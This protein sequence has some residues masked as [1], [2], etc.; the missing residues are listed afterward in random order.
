[1]FLMK[2]GSDNMRLYMAVTADKYELPLIVSDRITEIAEYT[3][4]SNKSVLESI[5]LKLSGKYKKI[6]Y[7]KVEI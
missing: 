4:T 2:Q 7:V 1:M 6:K 5:R 3:G